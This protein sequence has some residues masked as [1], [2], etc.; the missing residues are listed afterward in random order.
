MQAR[1]DLEMAVQVAEGAERKDVEGREGAREV[2][3]SERSERSQ[4]SEK[5]DSVSH[6]RLRFRVM[7][8][9]IWATICVSW[10]ISCRR[11]IIAGKS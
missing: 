5:L 6:W 1:R 11:A 3:R 4:K 8:S 9:L 7:F 10:F 2:E